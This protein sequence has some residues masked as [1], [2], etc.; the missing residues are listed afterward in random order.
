MAG[1]YICFGC[2]GHADAEGGDFVVGGGNEI[3]WDGQCAWFW[4]VIH[5]PEMMNKVK[6]LHI[7]LRLF[8]FDVW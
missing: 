4:K 2:F 8:S 7:P 3:L 6:I 5:R 1:Y